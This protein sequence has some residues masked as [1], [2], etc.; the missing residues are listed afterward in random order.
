MFKQLYLNTFLYLMFIQINIWCGSYIAFAC[1]SSNSP[2]LIVLLTI[3]DLILKIFHYKLHQNSYTPALKLLMW[4]ELVF[5]FCKL[6]YLLI[7]ENNHTGNT[8]WT[9]HIQI[10]PTEFSKNCFKI[11]GHFSKERKYDVMVCEFL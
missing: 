1:S 10:S 6:Q 3:L 5:F 8:W 7:F 4:E 11:V 2:N 9:I